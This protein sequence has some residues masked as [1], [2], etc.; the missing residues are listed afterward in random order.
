[1]THKFQDE[2]TID[3][4]PRSQLMNMC[5]YMGIKAFGTDNMLRSQLRRVMTQIKTD[6][7]VLLFEHFTGGINGVRTEIVAVE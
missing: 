2:M 3:N 5:R 7:K 6:D 1:M 4:L